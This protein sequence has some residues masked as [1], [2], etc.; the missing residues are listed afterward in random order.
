MFLNNFGVCLD[1]KGLLTR[2]FIFLRARS[3]ASYSVVLFVEC[4]SFAK[5]SQAVYLIMIPV[6]DVTTADIPTPLCHQAPSH[7]TTHG[8][9]MSSPGL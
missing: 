7:Y 9:S 3:R 1:D 4:T 5:I 6:G 2:A 8:V